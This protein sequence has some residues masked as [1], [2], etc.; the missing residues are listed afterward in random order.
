ME[1]IDI[2]NF[3]IE[4]SG[5]H[6]SLTYSGVMLGRTEEVNEMIL[7]TLENSFLPSVWKNWPFVP[8]LIEGYRQN[9]EK[10][11][12]KVANCVHLTADAGKRGEKYKNTSLVVFWFSD[13]FFTSPSTKILEEVGKID[14]KSVSKEWEPT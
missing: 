13:D 5:I 8:L 10:E 1:S 2:G 12:P 14:W 9:L 4:I 11:L 3:R 6:Q 7:L